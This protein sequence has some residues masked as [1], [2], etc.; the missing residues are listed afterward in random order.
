MM[1]EE[2]ENQIERRD[3]GDISRRSETTRR[4][5]DAASFVGGLANRRTES[6]LPSTVSTNPTYEFSL[7]WGTKGSG[8]GEFDMPRGVAVASDGSVYVADSRNH[9]IQKFTP[10]GVFVSKWGTEGAGDEQFE[11]PE[12]VAVAL[13][14]SVYVADTENNRIQKFTSEGVFVSQWGTQGTGEGEFNNPT[15]IAVASDGSVYVADTDNDR[16]QKFTTEGTFVSKWGDEWYGEDEGGDEEFVGTGDGDLFSPK[17]VAVASDG[18]VYIAD[19]YNNRIQ[20]FTSEGVFVSTWG[21]EGTG[22][23]QFSNPH[24]IAVASD[25]SVY[26]A[27]W[28]NHRIQKFSPVPNR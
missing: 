12:D 5:S 24:G 19:T 2:P 13:D 16:I 3:P 9:R 11:S 21:T 26:V 14:G 23:G 4:G 7:K 10:E 15:G 28:T 25:G 6:D 18:S 8:E 22:D 27:N 17:G 1:P 20:Q